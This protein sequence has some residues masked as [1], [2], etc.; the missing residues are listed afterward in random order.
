MEQGVDSLVAVGVRSWFL[1]EL[2]IDMPV[3]KVLGGTSVADLLDDASDRLPA[4]I[5][6]TLS[7]AD[8][9]VPVSATTKSQGARQNNKVS[10]IQGTSVSDKAISLVSETWKEEALSTEGTCLLGPP[11]YQH[12][13]HNK[14]NMLHPRVR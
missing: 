7:S 10:S 14:R 12:R 8:E 1:K 4:S 6:P 13:N 2:D 9:P 11:Q 3:L 5:V